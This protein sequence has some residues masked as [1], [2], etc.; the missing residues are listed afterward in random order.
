MLIPIMDFN[1]IST[2]LRLAVAVIGFDFY[3]LVLCFPI[4]AAFV[5][6]GISVGLGQ[7]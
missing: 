3:F 5:Y 7:L 4:A 6:D 1:R 2:V